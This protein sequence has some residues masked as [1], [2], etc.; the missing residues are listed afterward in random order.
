MRLDC[1]LSSRRTV[2]S[3]WRVASF[4]RSSFEVLAWMAS[5][6]ALACSF[7][8]RWIS[9][10]CD[11]SAC[12]SRLTASSLLLPR[13]STSTFTCFSSMAT[14]DS[15]LSTRLSRVL[16][17]GSGWEAGMGISRR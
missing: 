3:S 15:S 8:M 16:I 14:I 5:L 7:G 17:Q 2:T 1:D 4:S 6:T 11:L 12:S 13:V 9:V 10:S